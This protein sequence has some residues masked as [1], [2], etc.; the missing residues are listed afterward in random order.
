MKLRTSIVAALVLLV[1][2]A[3]PA[4]AASTLYELAANADGVFGSTL[5]GEPP[6]P[7]GLDTTGIDFVTGLGTMTYTQ[8]APGN[9]FVIGFFDLDVGIPADL[10]YNEYG[11]VFGSPGPGQSWEIDEPSYFFGDIWFNVQDGFLDNTNAIP[12]GQDDDIGMAIG[13]D[14]SLPPGGTAVIDFTVGEAEPA[15][16]FYLSQTDV[17]TGETVYLSSTIDIT[18][19]PEPLTA[20]GVI[21]AAASVGGYVRKRK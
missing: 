2:A 15:S 1:A 3:S 6:L 18:V 7:P 4:T 8:T 13:W 9:H 16:G 5:P 12:Q 19:I 17:D 21:F 10:Y 20:L 11:T 14:Y